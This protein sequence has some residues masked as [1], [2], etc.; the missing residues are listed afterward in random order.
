MT[1][2]EYAQQTRELI[3]LIGISEFQASFDCP[4]PTCLHGI[5][6]LPTSEDQWDMCMA[7]FRDSARQGEEFMVAF[8]VS[9]CQFKVIRCTCF[10]SEKKAYVVA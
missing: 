8:K 3:A 6:D 5:A 7:R 9:E 4:N 10:G 1:I 2:D